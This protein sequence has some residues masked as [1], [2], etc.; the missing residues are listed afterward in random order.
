[1]FMGGY[2]YYI[3]VFVSPLSGKNILFF[4]FNRSVRNAQ[5]FCEIYVC[6]VTNK[7]IKK[8]LEEN[9]YVCKLKLDPPLPG[10]V[11]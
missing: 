4:T 8:K 2:L 5:C 7:R 9:F 6:N 10:S 3:Y 1:M 11:I